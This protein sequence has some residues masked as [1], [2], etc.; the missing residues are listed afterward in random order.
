MGMQQFS[1][2]CKKGKK[3]KKSWGVRG[4]GKGKYSV[5]LVRKEYGE[6]GGS[7]LTSGSCC[8]QL[9]LPILSFRKGDLRLFRAMILIRL[10]WDL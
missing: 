1:V 2:V 7:D 6:W 8:C 3:K 4:E 5:V 9:L 10:H